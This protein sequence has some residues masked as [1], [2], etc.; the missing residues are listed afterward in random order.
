MSRFLCLVHLVFGILLQCLGFSASYTL[1]LRYYC[2]VLVR[3]PVTGL[4]RSNTCFSSRVKIRER[5][6]SE[7][8]LSGCLLNCS[9]NVSNK[10]KL[11][12]Q[13]GGSQNSERFS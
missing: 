9:V 1:C 5:S 4:I 8:K 3:L 12:G 11:E 10:Q 7:Q 13:G 6:T 2:N